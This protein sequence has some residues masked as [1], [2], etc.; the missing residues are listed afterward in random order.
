MARNPWLRFQ[1]FVES[2]KTQD[3]YKMVFGFVGKIV[4]WGW[5]L[6]SLVLLVLGIRALWRRGG[7]STLLAWML[8]IPIVFNLLTSV[9][10]IG[11]HRFRIQ[12]L[13]FSILLQMFG[14]YSLFSKR[15]FSKGMDGKTILREGRRIS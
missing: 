10:T 5:M 4:S 9:A 8:A 2:A 6:G 15:L 14:A 1:P 11:D 3:G 12:T 13:T 7:I